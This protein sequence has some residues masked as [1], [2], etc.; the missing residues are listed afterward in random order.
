M[1][2]AGRNCITE[3]LINNIT[4]CFNRLQAAVAIDPEL[5]VVPPHCLACFL[6]TLNHQKLNV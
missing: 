4:T 2:T 3:S 6:L 5:V 1:Q